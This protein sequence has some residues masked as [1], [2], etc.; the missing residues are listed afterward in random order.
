M[1]KRGHSA[2]SIR[3]KEPRRAAACDFDARRRY[4][5]RPSPPAM[6]SR[7]R[8]FKPLLRRIA[9][10]VPRT[11]PAVHLASASADTHGAMQTLANRVWD[12]RYSKTD[13]SGQLEHADCDPLDYT[14]HPFIYRHAI[15][16][17]LTGDGDR[18]WLDAIC[19]D[20]LKGRAGHVLSLGCGTAIHEEHLLQRG[21]AERV[22]G[23][24]MSAQAVDAARRRLDTTP[25]GSRI[26]LRCGD[27]IADALPSHAFDVVLVEAAIHHFVR[28]EEMFELMWRVLKPSGLLVYD[29]YVG[30]D[31][32]QHGE[33]LMA[34]LNRVN[35]CLDESY[36]RDFESGLPRARVDPAPLD[37]MLKYDP[38]EGVHASRILPLTYQYFEVVDRRDYG[39]A[40]L[41]PFM[42][43]ILTNWNF[44]DPKDRSVMRLIIVLE[45][46]LTRA[47]V[48]PT[49]QTLVVARPRVRPTRPLA[50]AEVERI[51]YVGW[52]SPV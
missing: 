49:H 14:R 34:L 7:M 20:Y 39:G 31:H 44:A 52:Q 42:S 32:H 17:P 12:Q 11:A 16:E 35:A 41:R 36:R 45:Q 33:E 37:W 23:Y 8:G 25:Y 4:W 9:A 43:R 15:S 40:V 24:E 46:E 29:E 13:A 48:I 10:R 26:E 1:L 47:G 6:S 28:I 21:F 2:S 38:T 3:S 50:A 22:V 51:A 19:D 18:F 5:T 30:P 27:P